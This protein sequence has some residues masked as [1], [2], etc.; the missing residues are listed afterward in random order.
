M[1]L[2]VAATIAVAIYLSGLKQDSGGPVGNEL[3]YYIA[4]LVG[5]V[6]SL[7]EN[8]SNPTAI[9]AIWHNQTDYQKS[10]LF[11]QSMNKG[12][13]DSTQATAEHRS[14]SNHSK[15]QRKK[16]KGKSRRRKSRKG[17]R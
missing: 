16:N 7:A 10:P 3:I 14:N 17:N 13:N 4:V 8:L 9:K 12:N 1:T 11:Q 15:P 6:V 2:P 5:A